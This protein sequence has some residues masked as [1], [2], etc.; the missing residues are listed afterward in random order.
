MRRHHRSVARGS[1]SARRWAWLAALS[2]AVLP[3]C[4]GYENQ[5]ASASAGQG[6]GVSAAG[7]S[8]SGGA[9][10]S[11]GVA[12]A[13]ENGVF[14]G[15]SPGALN[16]NNTSLDADYVTAMLKG[17]PGHFA[18]KGGDAQFGS[19]S[20]M[21]DGPRPDDW[22]PMRKEGAII[23]GTGGDNSFTGMGDFFEGAMTAGYHRTQPKTPSRPTSSRLGTA[24]ERNA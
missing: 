22:D 7:E 23:L 14:A 2:A 6:N 21:H 4:G 15:Q 17:E 9:V 3:A 10:G 16:P 18:I 8:T 19:L 13:L 20:T 12:T 1:R 5:G 24:S 11:G